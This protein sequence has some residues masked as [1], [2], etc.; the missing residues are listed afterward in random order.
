M[1]AGQILSPN[2]ICPKCGS[3]MFMPRRI[4]GFRCHKCRNCGKIKYE[5][6]FF[7]RLKLKWFKYLKGQRANPA[8]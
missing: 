7:E 1:P 5:K 2:P 4:K 6:S 3:Y 8:K